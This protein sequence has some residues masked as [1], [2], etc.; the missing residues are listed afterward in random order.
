MPTTPSATTLV[1]AASVTGAVAVAAS[2][3]VNLTL[4]STFGVR[5]VTYTIVGNH[6]ST[7]SNPTITP[8]AGFSASFTMPAGAGQAYLIETVI[9]GGFD[10]NG[11]AAAGYRHRYVIGVNEVDSVPGA[12]GE[13][14][15]RGTHG[16][17]KLLNT[18]L[19]SRASVTTNAQTGTSYTIT[20]SD[21]GKLVTLTNASAIALTL[22]EDATEALPVNFACNVYQGGAGVVSAS[23]EGSDTIDSTLGVAVSPV[24]LSGVGAGASI[25]KRGSGDWV[26]MGSFA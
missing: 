3:A 20:A 10:D 25:W 15:E 7:A 19:A 4:A 14:T 22:P 1:N 24:S 12:L 16:W 11:S 6:A 26:I 18:A 13:K 8:G 21:A 5:S 17:L 9:N 2:S 23:P